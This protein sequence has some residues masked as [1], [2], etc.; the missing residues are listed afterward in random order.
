M[1]GRTLDVV[2]L[3]DER[4]ENPSSR[5]R[6]LAER[7]AGDDHRVF[8]VEGGEDD[9]GGLGVVLRF[10]AR[11]GAEFARRRPR[12]AGVP[13]GVSVLRPLLLPATR[14]LFREANASLLVPRFVDL[15]HD[16]G[17]RRGPA[18]IVCGG[19]ETTL[20]LLDQLAPSV[21]AYGRPRRGTVV[22]H[23]EEAILLRT[24]LVLKDGEP[25]PGDLAALIERA[26]R[27]EPGVRPRRRTTLVSGLGW[28]GV[29]YAAARASTLLT[30][31]IAGRLLGPEE[32]GRANLVIAAAAYLQIAFMLGFPLATSK[33]VA[34]EID[35]GRRTRLI[36]TARSRFWG[37][38]SSSCRFS[39]PFAAPCKGWPA[40]LP[41]FSISRS[42]CRS[43]PP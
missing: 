22:S 15:L 36:S 21:V 26:R 1:K 19:D 25:N 11:A 32:Y 17:Q 30:Q 39:P 5:G 40:C 7:W 10:A 8:F 2:I 18:V 24:D 16:R 37:G 20:A 14:K 13:K 42:S 3:S 29:L 28:I 31:L 27:A 38:L 12:R 34:E 4:W 33:L 6:A 43:R 23:A 9:G 41:R 35:E